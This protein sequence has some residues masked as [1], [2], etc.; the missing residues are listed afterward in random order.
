MSRH[1]NI[2]AR[3]GASLYTAEGHLARFGQLAERGS[4]VA[5]V[6]HLAEAAHAG[7]PAA[8][9]QL[10]VCYLHGLGVP[11]SLAEARHWLELAAEAGDATA[12]TELASL[13]LRG[14]SGPYERGP[15]VSPEDAARAQPDHRLAAD[16]AR[17]AAASGSAQAQ[18]LLAF[19]IGM[20]PE[21][22][23]APDEADALYLESSEAGWPLGQLGHAMVM[24]RAGTFESMREAR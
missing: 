6:R 3:F 9:S 18:A 5:A 17:R 13:A 15:F 7:L 12:Q 8:R 23:E 16:L 14:I 11:V 2:F 24:L 1:A 20:A 10:G 22:A 19:I 4:A 21:M